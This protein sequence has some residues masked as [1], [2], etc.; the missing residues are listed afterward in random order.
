M[1]KP[2]EKAR[3]NHLRITKISLFKE[4]N[5]VEIFAA[6]LLAIMAN[7]RFPVPHKFRYKGQWAEE[8]H[9]KFEVGEVV[10]IEAIPEAY[11]ANIY[12]V[13]GLPLHLAGG[14][15]RKTVKTRF[16]ILKI[17]KGPKIGEWK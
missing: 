6:T 11:Q 7:E 5:T 16:L 17:Y 2:T 9:N 3:F 10:H 13:R 12:G 14:R 15:I 8:V 1:I 4:N